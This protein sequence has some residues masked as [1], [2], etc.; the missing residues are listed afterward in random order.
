MPATLTKSS[1]PPPYTVLPQRDP[2]SYRNDARLLAVV[3][4]AYI[5]G[6]IRR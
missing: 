1:T 4:A 3:E 2:S 6:A 5:L